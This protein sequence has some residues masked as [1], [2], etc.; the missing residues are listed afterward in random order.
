MRRLRAQD[1]RENVGWHSRF[2]LHRIRFAVVYLLSHR[3]TI[4]PFIGCSRPQALCHGRQRQRETIR[5]SSSRRFGR[6]CHG[7]SQSSHFCR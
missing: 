1:V 3:A 7:K 5:P 4:L 6:S 2:V